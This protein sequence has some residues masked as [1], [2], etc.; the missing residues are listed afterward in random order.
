MLLR[1]KGP[2][3]RVGELRQ[4]EFNIMVRGKD[5]NGTVGELR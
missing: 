5:P 1:E 2:W 3:S 4:N